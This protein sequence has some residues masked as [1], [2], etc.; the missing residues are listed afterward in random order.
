MSD[1]ICEKADENLHFRLPYVSCVYA[2]LSLSVRISLSSL[3]RKLL[4]S[5][6]VSCRL[7]YCISICIS[8]LAA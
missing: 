8:G 2:A 6:G 3:I 1:S 5:K 7:D 4:Y